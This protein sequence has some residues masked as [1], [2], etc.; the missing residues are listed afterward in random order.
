MRTLLMI[1]LFSSCIISCKSK[2]QK[3]TK[4][5]PTTIETKI[6]NEDYITK[7]NILL[8]QKNESNVNGK[9]RFAQSGDVVKMK[10]KIIGLSK[11][12]HA[13]HIH[14]KSDL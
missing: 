3:N 12:M 14:E 11:G 6:S 1:V 5:E 4:T 10:A 13:I 8:N 9:V 7:L 2:S